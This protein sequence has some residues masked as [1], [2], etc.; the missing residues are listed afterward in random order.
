M[1]SD[2][3]LGAICGWVIGMWT[4]IALVWWRNR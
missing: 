4:M 1:I 2:W 3:W